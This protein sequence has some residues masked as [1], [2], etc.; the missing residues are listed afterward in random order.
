MLTN[1]LIL[2][3]KL[4]VAKFASEELTE[5]WKR[6]CYVKTETTSNKAFMFE[7]RYEA[8]VKTGFLELLS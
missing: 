5:K 3:Y 4:A 7:P 6:I 2:S 1:L 8:P